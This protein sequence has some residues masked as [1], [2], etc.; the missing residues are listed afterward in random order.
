[1][2]RS[3]R[4]FGTQVGLKVLGSFALAAIAPLALTAILVVTQVT[5]TLKEQAQ[6]RLREAGSAIGQQL[7][8]RLLI[9]DDALGQIATSST[10]TESIGFEAVMLVVDGE[11]RSLL[12]EPFEIPEFKDEGPKLSTI[13]IE[14]GQGDISMLLARPIRGGMA[15]ARLRSSYFWNAAVTLPEGMNVCVIRPF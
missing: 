12:G 10:P 2:I 13:N 3:T 5:S 9:L 8:D 15:V 6:N 14:I 11:P 4:L 1:M 7:L